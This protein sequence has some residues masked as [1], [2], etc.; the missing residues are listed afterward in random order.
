MVN[1]VSE[2][3]SGF[4]AEIEGSG[5]GGVWGL[6]GRVDDIDSWIP[7]DGGSLC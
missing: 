3:G 7:A 4:V 2:I 1:D 5:E 6:V